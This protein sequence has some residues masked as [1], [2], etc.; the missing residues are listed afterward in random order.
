MLSTVDIDRKFGSG[1]NQVHAL[2]KV[3]INILPGRMTILRGRSG[4][5]KTCLINIMGALDQPTAGQ[6]FYRGRDIAKDSEHRRDSL[7]RTD[8]GFIFQ[9]V[10]L[11]PTMTAYENVD[12]ALRLSGMGASQRDRRVKECLEYVEM[13]KRARHRPAELSGGE[14]QRVAIARAICHRP[15][16]VFADEPTAELDSRMGLAVM[17]LMRELVAH[18]KLTIVLT[19]HDPNMFELADDVYTLENGEV[20]EHIHVTPLPEGGASYDTLR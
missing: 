16:I 18:E 9:S 15:G 6:V 11:M 2:K 5:G 14:Q 17:K 1:Q 13:E 10:A 3:S 19:T 4:S 12:F 7:R 8:F 20:T